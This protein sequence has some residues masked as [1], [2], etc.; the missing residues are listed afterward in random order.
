M[1]PALRRACDRR[2]RAAPAGPRPAHPSSIPPS[3]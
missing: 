2:L 1:F 3:S